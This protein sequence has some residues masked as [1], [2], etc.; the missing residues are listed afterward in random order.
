[1]TGV[2]L[3]L[4]GE[5][6]ALAAVD[7]MLRRA[8]NPRGLFENIGMALVT[9]TQMRFERGQAPDGSPWP[10]S[11]RVIAHGG[12]TL[13]ETARLMRSITSIA[14]DSGV[15]VGTNVI[16]AAIQQFGGDIAHKARSGTVTFKRSKKSGELLPGF[17]KKGRG[18]ETRAV[19]ISAHTTRIP[20][21]PFIGLDDDDTIEIARLA[22]DW[23]IGEA[24]GGGP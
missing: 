20:A 15:E 1:M 11:L 8:R 5:E 9:S 24:T 22:E 6:A 4:D 19:S 2:R 21:R 14:S 12:R 18:T 10:P 3:H 17:R 23:L 16:Y 13:V 7:G